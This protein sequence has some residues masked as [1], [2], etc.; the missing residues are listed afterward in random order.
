LRGCGI[1]LAALLATV[2]GC[3]DEEYGVSRNG[4]SHISFFVIE[5]QPSLSPDGEYVYYIANDTAQF[6]YS[7]VYRARVTMPLREKIYHGFSFRS[8]SI[9]FDNN[10]I[11]YLDSDKIRYY[12]ISDMRQWASGIT[13]GFESIV[14]IND[15][16]LVA[17]RNDSLF[18]IDES[19][20]SSIFILPGW[21]PTLVA[22]DTF[23]YFSR[24]IED[25]TYHIVRYSFGTDSPET[26]L[27]LTTAA[28]PRW[29]TLDI[30][31]GHMAYGLE[32][33]DQKFIYTTEIGGDS[34]IF[35]DSTEYLKPYIL[36][37]NLLIYTG[38]DGRFY[39]SGFYGGKGVP[40]IYVKTD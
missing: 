18:L 34:S 32:F 8:P 15:G 5:T 31:S 37:Y 9:A 28:R 6:K 1:I 30:A 21:D 13:D 2:S 10:T 22:R 3:G 39:Q 36:N 16:S 17:H 4:D 26:L 14:F 12:R 24:S 11:A 29:P 19:S 35:I 23:V 33:F 20:D 27:T 7:G 38:P 25:S 40:F